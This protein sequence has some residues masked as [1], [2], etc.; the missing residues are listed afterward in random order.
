MSKTKVKPKKV[1]KLAW[2]E[3]NPVGVKFDEARADYPGIILV[4]EFPF[5]GPSTWDLLPDDEDAARSLINALEEWI[6]ENEA[7][8][9]DDD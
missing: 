6:E 5:G 3:M 2:H 4:S 8:E 1:K 7:E 9:D